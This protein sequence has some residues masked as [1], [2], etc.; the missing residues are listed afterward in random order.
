MKNTLRCII[1]KVLIYGT[2]FIQRHE[3]SYRGKSKMC[4]YVLIVS[5]AEILFS[6]QRTSQKYLL[7]GDIQHESAKSQRST[8]YDE[9]LLQ[10]SP[11]SE[12]Q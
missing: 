11:P 2:Q 12:L 5:F 7:R 9:A 4:P 10:M 6:F 3:H 1:P 8:S